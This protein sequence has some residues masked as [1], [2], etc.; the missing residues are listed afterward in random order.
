MNI[1][2]YTLYPIYLHVVIIEDI[3]Q[4]MLKWH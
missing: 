2:K 4:I 1:E 3:Q